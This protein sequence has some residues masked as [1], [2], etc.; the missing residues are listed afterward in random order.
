MERRG[1]EPDRVS[2]GEVRKPDIDAAFR[3]GTVIDRAL[4]RAGK[5]VALI[6]KESLPRYKTC[7]GGVVGRAFK[8]LPSDVK[9][10]VEHECFEAEANFLESGMSFRVKRDVPIVSMTMRADLDKALAD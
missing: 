10:P 1:N 5:R 9:I 2:E 7:G 6:E 8:Y 4:G 3:D